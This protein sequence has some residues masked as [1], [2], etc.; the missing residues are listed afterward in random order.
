MNFYDELAQMRRNLESARP[1]KRPDLKVEDWLLKDPMGA[2]YKEAE[3]LLNS[4][5]VCYAGIVQANKLLFKKGL[6]FSPDCPAAFVYSDNEFIN[7]NPFLLEDIAH[8]IYS[9]KGI[10]DSAPEELR[11]IVRVVADEYERMFNVPV[12]VKAV[13]F[14]GKE[15]VAAEYYENAEVLFT[16]AFVFRKYVPGKA[17][18]GRV[19]PVLAK[20]GE[21]KSIM[22]LPG[23]YW[24]DSFIQNCW[25]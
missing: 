12:P 8:Y 2:V 6:I 9:F 23:N 13:P 5:Q 18:K 7:A 20:P 16:T 4:G 3:T 19:V 17:L 11:E 1:V 10:P 25:Q 21:C 14:E 24:T 22:I 15:Q